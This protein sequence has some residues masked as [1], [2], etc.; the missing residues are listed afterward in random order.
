V[1]TTKNKTRTPE[2]I[3]DDKQAAL[4]AQAEATALLEEA[5]LAAAKVQGEEAMR[6]A[7]INHPN[8]DWQADPV[9]GAPLIPKIGEAAEDQIPTEPYDPDTEPADES[10]AEAR[11]QSGKAKTKAEQEAEEQ[12]KEVSDAEADKA[13]YQAAMKSGAP[14]S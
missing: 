3:E 14:K 10:Q 2:S 7:R 1:A 5:N 9:T 12:A 11:A 8:T 13:A 4:D 6:I